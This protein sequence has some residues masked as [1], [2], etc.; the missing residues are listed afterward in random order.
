MLP[1]LVAVTGITAVGAVVPVLKKTGSVAEVFTTLKKA[2][3]LAPF[4]PRLAFAGVMLLPLDDDVAVKATVGPAT[5]M[6]DIIVDFLLLD[7]GLR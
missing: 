5:M 4:K 7:H 3:P 1:V 2:G 6:A